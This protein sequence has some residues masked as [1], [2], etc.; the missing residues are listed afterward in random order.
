M[1]RIIISCVAVAALVLFAVGPAL[2][3]AALLASNPVDGS[4]VTTAPATLALTFNEPVSPVALQLFN[5]R[6]EPIDLTDVHVVGNTL[7]IVPPAIGEG[8]H[9]LS[10]RVIS[11]DGH[12]FG[13]TEVFSVGRA[14]AGVSVAG[15]TATD[16]AVATALWLMRML[17]YGGLFFGAGGTFFVFWVAGKKHLSPS[18]RAILLATVAIGIAAA[19]VALGLQGLDVLAEPLPALLEARP[20]RVGLAT[21][22]GATMLVGIGAMALAAASVLSPA[23]APARGLSAAALL[24]VGVSLAVSGHASS[25][26]PRSLTGLVV[27]VHAVAVAFWIGA[28]VPLAAILARGEPGVGIVLRR[29]SAAVPYAIG[30]LVAAGA[31]LVVVQLPS[32]SD[33]WT[34]DYGLLLSAKLIA[35]AALLAIALANRVWLTGRADNASA[36]RNLV[37]AIGTEIVLVVGA[38]GLVATWRF[39][40]PPR[41]LGVASIDLPALVH[42]MQG[43]TLA[44]IKVTPG[45]VGPVN[46][47]I[48]IFDLNG[49][50][51]DVKEVSLALS[52]T[53]GGIEPI[54]RSA[55]KAADGSWQVHG[56]VVPAG[57]V[58]TAELALLISDFEQIDLQGLV[59]IS[60]R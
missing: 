12:P 5:D 24:A 11:T 3:H 58:W 17:V 56:L 6:G 55:K 34:T 42:L 13:G 28:L 29:F 26:P 44:E 14:T 20:W 41:S 19:A 35:V 32:V 39:T 16:P 36:R 45:R 47:A 50:Q 31:A 10:W 38:L 40:P 15:E 22:Y 53:G 7:V 51:L 1:R 48:S 30:S 27:L 54:T 18:L 4:T 9:A 52:N 23:A 2:G 33:L 21:T 57:G 8:T 43:N 37:R 49:R 59:A 46:L 25:A 60:P